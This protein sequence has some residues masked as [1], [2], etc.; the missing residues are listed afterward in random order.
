[1]SKRA[2]RHIK[3]RVG[4]FTLVELM[5]TVSILAILLAIGAPNLR[6][7]LVKQQVAADANA[8]A[9]AFRL[10]R[11]EALK[12]SGTVSVCPSP[13]PSAKPP[14][15][16]TTATTNW[17][18]GWLVFIDYP[19]SAGHAGAFESD[20]D[21]LLHIEQDI[22]SVSITS[23]TSDTVVSFLANG[24]SSNAAATYTITPSVASLA[25]CVTVSRQGRSNVGNC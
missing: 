9:S 17:S 8:L 10:A 2:F 3:G 15:C 12:R 5:V 6:D 18:T 23:S 21:T 7:F 25:Q 13:D 19:N 16:V 1:M 22:K 4:G 14:A 11:S 24:V 20:R